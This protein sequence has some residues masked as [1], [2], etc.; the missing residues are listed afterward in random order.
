MNRNLI[1][2]VGLG[3]LLSVVDEAIAL[4]P[5]QVAFSPIPS[6][7]G[8]IQRSTSI[9]PRSRIESVGKPPQ[10]VSAT[11]IV[12]DRYVSP[13]AVE[14]EV[15]D[16]VNTV[17]LQEARDA[18]QQF[19]RHSAQVS[20]AECELFLERLSGLSPEQQEDWLRRYQV[21]REHIERGQRIA[22]SARQLAIAGSLRRQQARQQVAA[23][24]ARA[25]L[26]VQLQTR[27]ADRENTLVASKP[28]SNLRTVAPEFRPRYDPFELVFDPVSLTGRARRRAAASVLPGDLPA[29]DPANF[30][31]QPD[32]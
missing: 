1:I 17:E 12:S 10:I 20:T 7:R 5:D 30:L 22:G 24:I 13:D 18:V 29:D 16:T 23:D 19:C 32:S 11:E 25:R 9:S 4:S 2:A 15:A 6:L 3:A 28:F 27:P 8:E 31:E 26:R 21:R 14:Q